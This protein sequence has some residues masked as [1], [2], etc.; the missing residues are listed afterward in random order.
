MPEAQLLAAVEQVGHAM[1]HIYG[2]TE[3]PWPITTLKQEEHRV[4]G[5]HLR[6]VG[7]PTTVCELR[8][9]SE[10]G[11]VLGDGEVGEIQVRGRNV[12]A[13]YYRDEEAT[14]AVLRDGWLSSGDLGVRDADGYYRIVD[15]KKDVI[16][17]GG[18]NVYAKEVEMALCEHPAVLEAAVVG[19][20]HADFGEL[21]AAFVVPKDG[22]RLTPEEIDRFCRGRLSGYKCPRRI[23]VVADLPKNSSGKLLKREIVRRAVD[24]G[25]QTSR[26]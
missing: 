21:V 11:E 6:S 16:I 24:D 3:A 20:T 19:L 4:D 15:R 8:I 18:F 7:K 10:S 14:R 12:M 13:G 5:P 9:V 17:S 23:D 1:L 2:M 26:S 22:E 25:A